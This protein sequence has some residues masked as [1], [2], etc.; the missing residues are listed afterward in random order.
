MPAAFTY[1]T[2]KVHWELL[3]RARAVE[4]QCYVLASAQ[5]GLHENG[6][7]TWGQSMLVDPWGEILAQLPTGEGLVL[8]KMEPERLRE[9]R[10]NLPALN[11]RQF[12]EH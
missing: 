2:G 3:I 12:N 5:G 9:I 10:A 11:H 7:R 1:T 6:R 4:N 8:G